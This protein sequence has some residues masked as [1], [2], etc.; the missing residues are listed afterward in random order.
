MAVH[1]SNTCLLHTFTFY[2]A[3]YNSGF[4]ADFNDELFL[5]HSQL[6]KESLLV[7][8]PRLNKMLQ[9]SLKPLC[10]HPKNASLGPGRRIK[11][12]AITLPEQPHSPDPYP[13]P[14]TDAGLHDGKYTDPKEG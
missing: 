14:E 8:F 9:S 6:L 5:L 12:G 2:S 10:Q 3:D 13:A 7:S 11:S 4:N 1:S